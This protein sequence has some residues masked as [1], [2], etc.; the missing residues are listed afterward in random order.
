MKQQRNGI[1]YKMWASLPQHIKD[2][3]VKAVTIL[4]EV[5]SDDEED[6]LAEDW[7]AI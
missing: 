3:D 5:N 1:V 6:N 2:K 7:D 4:P